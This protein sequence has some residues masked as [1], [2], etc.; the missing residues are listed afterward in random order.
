[1]KAATRHFFYGLIVLSLVAPPFGV[2]VSAEEW[3]SL[4]T[5][6]GDPDLQ[7][8]W[9]N[10]TITGLERPPQ[11]PTLVLDEVM[12]AGVE[13]WTDNFYA[14]IDQL[15]KGDLPPSVDVGG[16]NTFWM[17]PGKRLARVGGEIRSSLI[18]DPRNG[19]L[20]YSAAGRKLLNERMAL[21]NVADNP[22]TRLLGERCLV[23]FG[24][25][26]GPPMLPVL[27]NNFYQIVQS[28]GFVVI[29]VEMNHNA[30]IIRLHGDPLPAQIQP[31]LGDSIGRWD[32]QTLVVETTQFHPAQSLRASLRHQLYLSPQAKVVERFTRI[33][34][35]EI[36]YE[37]SVDDPSVYS[38]NW[39]AEVPMLAADGPLYEYACH[40][41][42]YSMT[43]ILAG[44]RTQD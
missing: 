38:R 29:V 36:F 5:S 6:W 31:W 25:S 4:D 23:G 18:V 35:S 8:T 41:G 2:G 21:A 3:Q 37:F 28:P 42:N 12:A 9:T 11:L 39:R 34:E 43:G 44:E 33:S 13:S 16:Y 19:K 14:S 20:P 30:R 40:E 32:G 27:Y 22:E 26:G 1:M 15:P 7:G 17:D 10:A 24:S